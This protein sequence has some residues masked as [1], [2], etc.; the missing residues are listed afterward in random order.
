M[1]ASKF[2]G[3]SQDKYATDSGLHFLKSE[4]TRIADGVCDGSSSGAKSFHDI[5]QSAYPHYNASLQKDI[6]HKEV[7]IMKAF[8]AKT[9]KKD[10]EDLRT[11]L[12]GHKL[13]YWWHL[14]A[15]DCGG[16][17]NVFYDKWLGAADHWRESKGLNPTSFTQLTAFLRSYVPDIGDY[18][19]CRK[20]SRVES[21]HGL[22]NKY[23][24]KRLHYKYKH[25][26]SR[27]SLATCDWNENANKKKV[28]RELTTF[29]R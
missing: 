25:Y 21:Y 28:T 2:A 17:V 18:V 6:W 13:R 29:A 10:A 27:K 15:K 12:D 19:R 26:C 7:K 23:I 16:D 1:K 11:K 20:T 3:K 5:I 8:T 4:L 24:S 22:A 9:K 14:C